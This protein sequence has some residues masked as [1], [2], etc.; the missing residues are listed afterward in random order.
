M[1][2]SVCGNSEANK[3]SVTFNGGESCFLTLSLYRG[4]LLP[5]RMKKC[6]E[7]SGRRGWRTALSLKSCGCYIE[8]EEALNAAAFRY[9]YRLF[10][11]KKGASVSVL[12]WKQSYVPL[13]LTAG[14]GAFCCYRWM[15]VDDRMKNPGRLVESPLFRTP[16]LFRKADELRIQQVFP[17][18]V[19]CFLI[20]REA[21]PVRQGRPVSTSR[22]C[23]GRRYEKIR[24]RRLT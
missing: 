22:K 20:Q 17:I 6:R 11:A 5:V 23:A 7:A 12:F 14:A 15:P 24:R 10:S 16:Q 3:S 4:F 13:R 8:R 1:F 18:F 9:L 2:L 19:P 21:V